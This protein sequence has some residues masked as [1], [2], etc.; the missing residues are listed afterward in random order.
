M[1]C[2]YPVSPLG[3][4]EDKAFSTCLCDLHNKKAVL[5]LSFKKSGRVQDSGASLCALKASPSSLFGHFELRRILWDHICFNELKPACVIQVCS[6]LRGE[7]ILARAATVKM[8]HRQEQFIIKY[9]GSIAIYDR[10]RRLTGW[11]KGAFV[12]IILVFLVLLVLII[13]HVYLWTTSGDLFGYH[14]I[15]SGRC[16]GNGVGRLNTLLHLIINIL[17]TLVLASTNFFMQVLNAPSRAELDS[18]HEKGF[19]LDIGVPSPR[20]AFR[21]GRFKTIMWLLFFLSSIPIH[22][23]FNSAIFSTDHRESRFSY[24]V[25]DESVLTGGAIFDPGAS[26]SLAHDDYTWAEFYWDYNFTKNTWTNPERLHQT[27]E[28]YF[29]TAYRNNSLDVHA[30]AEDI[31][32]GRWHKLDKSDCNLLYNTSHCSGIRAYRSVAL[33]L[34]GSSGWNRSHLWDLPANESS[35]WDAYVPKDVDNSLWIAHSSNDPETSCSLFLLE[36]CDNSCNSAMA[37]DTSDSDMW[38]YPLFP[39]T[40]S[41]LE[42]VSIP[43]APDFASSRVSVEYCMVEPFETVCQ[44]G[45]ASNLLWIVSTWYYAHPTPFAISS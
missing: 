36:S 23:L 26:L 3:S 38:N 21:V 14:I 20:N 5:I 44:I 35:F 41:L 43:P 33:I 17:S 32:M 30:A 40:G 6:E 16:A 10:F 1:L 24:F 22:L 15:H 42:L 13:S 8:P 31:R 19:W 4:E 2:V 29:D 25:F 18:A 12:N 27:R 34:R 7:T 11:R 37:F 28:N 45:L 39:N 9:C